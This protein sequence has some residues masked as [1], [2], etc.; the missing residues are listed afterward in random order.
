MGMND[1][2][3]K[4]MLIDQ[5]RGWKRVLEMAIAASN[6]YIQKLAEEQIED[7]KAKLKF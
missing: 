7:L 4:G 5:L 3:Y 1:N 2:Q 6:T